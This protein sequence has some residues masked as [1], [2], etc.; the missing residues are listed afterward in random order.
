MH[1]C[2]LLL[3]LVGT[4]AEARQDITGNRLV[5]TGPVGF[6]Q[7]SDKLKPEAEKVLEAALPYLS[8]EKTGV[9]LF[10]I[11]G[12]TSRDEKG[13]YDQAVT[14]RRALA[15]A[16]WFVQRGVSCKRLLPVGF[17]GLVSVGN[18]GTE[19]GR[20]A[21]ER[22]EIAIAKQGQKLVEGKKPE[23]NGKIAKP[24][25]CAAAKALAPRE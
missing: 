3:A 9:T 14:E 5:L 20:K 2:L 1:R 13:G 17:G 11:E 21:N 6:I 16:L 19:E 8:D 25:L 15:V 4:G 10:R 18:H 23:L 7:G 24:E 22:I 12:H